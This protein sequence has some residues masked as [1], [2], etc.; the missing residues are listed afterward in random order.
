MSTQNPEL[1]PPVPPP[2]NAPV[3][4]G[5]A[6]FV[7]TPDVLA[8]P[9]SAPE[10]LPVWPY[11]I[12]GAALFLPVHPFTGFGGFDYYDQGPG[13]PIVAS[14][15]AGP[16]TSKPADPM[17]IGKQIYNGNCANCHQAS[18]E[19]QPGSYPPLGGSEWVVGDKTTLACIMLHG[20]QGPLTVKN[21][22]YG[23]QQMPG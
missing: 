1:Q 11:P 14:A 8:A 2:V 10:P 21:G 17:A 19:G 16:D 12:C 6:D 4:P 7:E 20:L 9:E 23:S 5:A 18:G 22:S 3:Q 15:G 13:M